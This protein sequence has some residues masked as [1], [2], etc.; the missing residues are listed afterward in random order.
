MVTWLMVLINQGPSTIAAPPW[1]T[2]CPLDGSPQLFLMEVTF[3][4]THLSTRLQ[5]KKQ[6]AQTHANA[7]LTERN[8]FAS[9]HKE[10]EE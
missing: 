3:T 2:N 8:A 5:K 10:E 6:Q 4:E 7:V 9:E 1:K